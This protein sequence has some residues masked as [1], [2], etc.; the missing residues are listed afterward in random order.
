MVCCTLDTIK[1]TTKIQMVTFF[2][3][4]W[5][6]CVY[7]M[8][9]I[10]M[11]I[12]KEIIWPDV[13]GGIQHPLLILPS[14]VHIWLGSSW[15]RCRKSDQVLVWSLPWW[16]ALVIC[17]CGAIVFGNM[18]CF[19]LKNIDKFPSNQGMDI[20]FLHTDYLERYFTKVGCGRCATG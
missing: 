17:Q 7:D 3:L 14:L 20:S 8:R 11:I 16:V 6:F 19:P 15:I 10:S 5:L 1:L 13:S 9:F 2:P 4:C 18:T 12:V